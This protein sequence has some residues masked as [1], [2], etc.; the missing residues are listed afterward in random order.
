MWSLHTTESDALLTS[1]Y[2]YGLL[3]T[4]LRRRYSAVW[5]KKAVACSNNTPAD[6]TLGC[7]VA[8]TED[9]PSQQGGPP[10]L[11]AWVGKKKRVPVIYYATRTH[12]QIVQARHSA[13]VQ[14]SEPKSDI[15]LAPESLGPAHAQVVRELKRSG[16]RPKM[17]ILVPPPVTFTMYRMFACL[18]CPTGMHM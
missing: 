14:K 18:R 4:L 17:A 16:L 11:P 15:L 1:C 9:V 2:I 8:S 6:S 3:S 13:P 5:E 12:S 7:T 10:G